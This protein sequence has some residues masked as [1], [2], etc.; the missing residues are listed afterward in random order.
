MMDKQVKNAF[1]PKDIAVLAVIF[2]AGAACFIPGG[3]WSGLGIIIL[4]CWAMTVPFYHHGYR[5]EGKKG[6]FR[7]EEILL[8]RENKEDILAW[9]DGRSERLDLSSR[10]TG[11]ALVDVYYRRQGDER[12]ARYFDY[13]DF[14]KGIEYPLHKVTEGQVSALESFAIDRKKDGKQ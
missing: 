6:V 14:A 9:L 1:L 5:L 13:G 10:Q 12:Y 11:G 3:G 8:S 7:A 2:A 4:L